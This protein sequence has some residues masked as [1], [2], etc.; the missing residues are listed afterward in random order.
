MRRIVGFAVSA[1][2]LGLTIVLVET[3]PA[4]AATCSGTTISGTGSVVVPSGQTCSLTG[5]TV[6]GNITVQSG[7]SLALVGSTIRGSVTAQQP[8]DLDI[9]DS[10]MA[11]L[12]IQGSAP[13]SGNS[14]LLCHNTIAGPV[15]INSVAVPVQFGGPG[16]GANTVCG[17]FGARFN[18]GQLA[19]IGNTVTGG[20]SV[21]NNTNLTFSSNAFGGLLSATGNAPSNGSGNTSNDAGA[22]SAT[23]GDPTTATSSASS[24]STSSS[25]SSSTSTS[26][27]TSSSSTTSTTRND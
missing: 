9:T 18:S 26:T 25:T 7:G 11:S 23:C 22:R 3:G 8:A 1:L 20:G 24:T 27:S 15:A 10:Y 17:P 6:N 14:F 2:V 4:S 12:S 21:A 5:V 13:G 16:C 19:I